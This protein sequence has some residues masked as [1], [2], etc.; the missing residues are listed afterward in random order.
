MEPTTPRRTQPSPRSSNA[1]L[2]TPITR[3]LRH[4]EQ[5]T[6]TS[7]PAT[8]S[9]FGSPALGRLDESG[10]RDRLRDAYWLLKEKEKNLFIAATVGQ[11]LVEAN[12]QLQSSY[13][14]IQGELAEIRRS[15]DRGGGGGGGGSDE[16]LRLHGRR[17][18]MY[19]QGSGDQRDEATDDGEREKQWARVHL[20]PLRAQLDMALERTDELLAEREDLAAQVF[21][22][23]QEQAAALRRAADAA[24]SAGEAQ[25][26]VEALEEDKARLQGELGEQRAFW[27]RRWA[28]RQAAGRAPVADDPSGGWA[29]DAAARIRAEQRADAMQAR[30]GEA[31]GEAEALRAQVQRLEDERAH[32]WE[33][34][35]ARWLASEE[36]LLELQ[37]AYQAACDALAAAEARIADLDRAPVAEVALRSEKTATSLLGELDQ[38]RRDAEAQQQALAREHGALRRAFARA[39][40]S[41]A[42]MKQQVARLSQLAASGATE[43]RMRRLEAALGEAE[44]QRQALLAQSMAHPRP[45]PAAEAAEAEPE[46]EPEGPALVAALRASVKAVAADRDQ[47]RRELRTAHL[48]RANEIQRSRDVEREAADTERRLRRALADLE[49]LRA[50]HEALKKPPCVPPPQPPQPPQQPP[51]PPPP[52]PPRK[53]TAA[54][55]ASDGR[56]VPRSRGGPMSLDFVINSEAVTAQVNGSPDAAKRRRRAS[57]TPNGMPSAKLTTSSGLAATAAESADLSDIKLAA[58]R[59]LKSWL[60]SLGAVHATTNIAADVSLAEPN[61]PSS[62][63]A[64]GTANPVECPAGTPATSDVKPAAPVDEIYINSRMSQKPIE[65][66][67]Q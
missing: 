14:Q 20:L 39:V 40:G 24:A 31:A 1:P 50:D 30:A 46:A 48:L 37:D 23:K 7:R 12:Q 56:L 8:M 13:E 47:A 10:L 55:L 22:L 53:R 51:P 11:E 45:P 34:Q 59:G 52:P 9:P 3:V 44:C 66:N 2:L 4:V 29:E 67:T 58:D 28:S 35:R 57:A 26:R 17:R 27:A 43:A 60:G 32:E 63:L 36:A 65:C 19:G 33:P 16:M 49:A 38:Q 18:S 5:L 54:G 62:S 41:Q 25:R 64:D 15:Q 6:P 21:G 42:R 61:T